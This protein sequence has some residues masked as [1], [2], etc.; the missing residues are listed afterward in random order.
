MRQS[1]W[2]QLSKARAVCYQAGSLSFRCISSL[3]SF[4]CCI[5]QGPQLL[6]E[7]VARVKQTGIQVSAERCALCIHV[8]SRVAYTQHSCTIT[9]NEKVWCIHDGDWKVRVFH[10][11]L[12]A[13]FAHRLCLH[14]T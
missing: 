11:R 1:C 13:M 5:S 14:I 12:T 6:R 4:L 10:L 9:L 2:N 8:D 7:S 3:R